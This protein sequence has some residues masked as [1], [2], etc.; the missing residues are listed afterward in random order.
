MAPYS[1]FFIRARADFENLAMA[2]A[3]K[4]YIKVTRNH[5]VKCRQTWR[6]KFIYRRCVGR[7]RFHLKEK[8]TRYA[9]VSA[10]EAGLSDRHDHRAGQ[11]KIVYYHT[12][13]QS[14]ALFVKQTQ[15]ASPHLTSSR[16]A[17]NDA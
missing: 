8:C 6:P 10:N 14:L 16:G 11:S 1:F 4:L 15:K 2:R 13:L 5:A 3:F 17:R 9:A 7:F 12:Y